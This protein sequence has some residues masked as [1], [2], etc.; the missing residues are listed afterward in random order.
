[1]TIK[2]FLSIYLYSIFIAITSGSCYFIDGTVAENRIPCSDLNN[3]VNAS[4]CCES[5]A[6]FDSCMNG[7]CV[8]SVAPFPGQYD[9]DYGFWRDS[10]SDPTWRDPVCVKIASC[11]KSRITLDLDEEQSN[12]HVY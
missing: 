10:C 2:R 11:E 1:M 3:T 6:F 7:I 9:N 12:V 8:V 4:M 5:N